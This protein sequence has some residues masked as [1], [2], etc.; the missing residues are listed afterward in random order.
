M[1]PVGSEMAA[2]TS[3]GE[4]RPGRVVVTSAGSLG[5]FGAG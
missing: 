2:T 1:Y 5:M 3:T 4:G